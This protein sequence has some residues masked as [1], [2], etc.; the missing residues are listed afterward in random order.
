MAKP[1]TTSEQILAV[2]RRSHLMTGL[3]PHENPSLAPVENPPLTPPKRGIGGR[4]IRRE[5]IK[6]RF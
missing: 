2:F 3:T 4:T 5:D 6:S 1:K